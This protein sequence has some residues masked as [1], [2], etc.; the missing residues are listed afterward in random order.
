VA[1]H[2]SDIYTASNGNAFPFPLERS[3]TFQ[4]DSIS[5][6]VRENKPREEAEAKNKQTNKERKKNK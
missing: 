4:S 1:N 3:G 5:L 6:F 2:N